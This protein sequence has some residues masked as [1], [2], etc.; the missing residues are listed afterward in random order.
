MSLCVCDFSVL[1][2]CLVTLTK[3]DCGVN[4]GR[5]CTK[6]ETDGQLAAMTWEDAKNWCL[7]QSNHSVKYRIVA[8]L[9]NDIKNQL[10]QF[11]IDFDMQFRNPWFG[12]TRTPNN[13]WKWVNGRTAD[14]IC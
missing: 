6:L 10:E 14:N 3:T 4:G 7:Q 1:F 2:S 12:A 5:L 9:D 8:V 13:K 11:I